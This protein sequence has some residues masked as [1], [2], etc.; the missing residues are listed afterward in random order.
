MQAVLPAVVQ[1]HNQ[2][3]AQADQHQDRE[4]LESPELEDN[5][6]QD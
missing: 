2:D 4:R 6:G 1:D 5:N 3:Q